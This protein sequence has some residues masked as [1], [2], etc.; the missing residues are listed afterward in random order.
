MRARKGV[1][2]KAGES[3]DGREEREKEGGR[4]RG[5]SEIDR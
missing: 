3:V 5:G 1:R 4:E 2:D